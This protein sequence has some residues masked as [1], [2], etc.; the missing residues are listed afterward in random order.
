MLRS[1]NLCVLFLAAVL[2]NLSFAD[3]LVMK[4]GDRVSGHIVKKDGDKLTFKTDSFGDITASWDAVVSVQSEAPLTVVLKNGKSALG[5]ISSSDGHVTVATNAGP[6]TSAPGDIA[7]IRNADEQRAY[8]RLES[9]GWT[10]LWAGEVN[11]GLAGTGGNARTETLTM[12]LNAARQTRTDK[13]YF[14]LN[15][16]KASAFTN[17][18]DSNTADAVRAAIGYD[19]QVSPRLFVN[20]FNNDEYDK[21]Q[22]L[23][24]R[25]VGGGG[26]GFHIVKGERRRLDLVGGGDYDHD[27]FSTSLTRSL[28]EVYWGDDFTQKLW[29]TTSLIQSFRMFD[30]VSNPGRRINFNLTATTMLRKRLSW[31]LALNDYYLSNPVAGRKTNDWVYTM[32]LGFKFGK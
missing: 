26:L 32:G 23:D 22:D 27:S 31:N 1:R 14:S 5:A 29:A 6:V 3:V 8:E 17:G 18:V 16:I 28:A 7:A 19:H 15:A 10:Q 24:F 9:P 11:L 2:A 12:G 13:T 20:V 4:N 21:F 30:D 25:F